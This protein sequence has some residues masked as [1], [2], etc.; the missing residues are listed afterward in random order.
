MAGNACQV[1]INN[2]TYWIPC[3]R[4]NDLH[5]LDGYLVNL[6]DTSLTL[7]VRYADET[8]Y[9]YISCSAF[10]SCTKRTASG[11]QYQSYVT[12]NY[13]FNGDIFKTLHFEYWVLFLLFLILGVRILWKR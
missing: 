8:V 3:D 10:A 6:S 7:R 4:V 5:Y 1:E 13:E 11:S 12:S 2:D 9:P